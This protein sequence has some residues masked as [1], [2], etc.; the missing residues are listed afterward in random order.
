MSH[1]RCVKPRQSEGGV[2]SPVSSVNVCIFSLTGPFLSL[3]G[4]CCCDFD[5]GFSIPVT[6][7]IAL[8]GKIALFITGGSENSPSLSDS[9]IVPASATCSKP[10]D[11]PYAVDY[12]KGAKV[13]GAPVVCGGNL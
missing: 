12:I 11:L 8:P 13:D 3:H 10:A 1:N 4:P 2:L 9:E 5:G 7:C 6:S